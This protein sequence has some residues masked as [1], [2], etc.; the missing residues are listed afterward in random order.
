MQFA[1]QLVIISKVFNKRVGR[2]AN[3]RGGK[4]SGSFQIQ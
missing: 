4:F 3:S 1:F 2:E